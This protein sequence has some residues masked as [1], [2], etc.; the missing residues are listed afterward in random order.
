MGGTIYLSADRCE[1]GK[2]T[3]AGEA[4][5]ALNAEPDQGIL[6]PRGHVALARPW[7]PLG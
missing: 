4:S 2:L 6:G 3:Q 5:E 7:P 1:R